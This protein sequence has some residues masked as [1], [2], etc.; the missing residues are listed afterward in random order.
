M[1]RPAADTMRAATGAVRA[2]TTMRISTDTALCISTG[3]AVR[4]ALARSPPYGARRGATRLRWALALRHRAGS[5]E[6][7]S[8]PERE[9]AQKRHLEPDA[10]LGYQREIAAADDGGL[11]EKLHIFRRHRL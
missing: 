3:G 10:R 1:R 9:H 2:G 6:A 5:H 8:R 11:V 4:H 7:F